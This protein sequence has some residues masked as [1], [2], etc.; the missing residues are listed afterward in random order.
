MKF[1]TQADG[2]ISHHQKKFG[3][4]PFTHKRAL[5]Q[6]VLAREKTRECAEKHARARFLLVRARLFT[7]FYQK[8]FGGGLCSYELKSKIS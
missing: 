5:V 6:N 4:N 1:H 3:K 2:R 7:D 8:S